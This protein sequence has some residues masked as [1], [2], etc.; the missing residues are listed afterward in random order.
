[1]SEPTS[2]F[3]RRDAVANKAPSLFSGSP[4][5]TGP[6][7]RALALLA[8]VLVIGLILV[9]VFG[10]Y[11]RRE[12]VAGFIAPTSGLVRVVPPRM[13]VVTRVEVIDD[14][15]VLAG[16]ALLAI[17]SLRATA[18]GGD[19]DAAHVVALEQ[20]RLNLAARIAREAELAEARTQDTARRIGELQ[21][22]VKKIQ[23]QR[24]LAEERSELL[25]REL[26]RLESLKA[27]A[28]ISASLLDERR[29][30]V[31]TAQQ[32]D[33]ALAREQ[34]RLQSG[35][36]ALEAELGLKPLELSARQDELAARILEID[37]R[38]AEAEVQ[39]E[40][41][42]RAPVS[43]RVTS[44]LAFPGQ[45]VTPNQAMLAI[46]PD[47]ARM[48]A[49]LLVPS[50]AAGFIRNGQEVRL[51]YDAFPHQRFGVHRA[52]VNSVSRTMLKPGDQV[53]PLSLQSPA[54]RV[55][56]TL[57]ADSVMAYGE[58]IPLQPDLTLQAD[59]VRE[60][61]RIIEWIFD[62]VRAAVSAL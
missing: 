52:V 36:A 20:E 5:Q 11:E 57:D 56:A 7:V 34:E 51:R 6:A 1:M 31:L 3:F 9:L 45:S 49:V 28:H 48:Q 16:Q 12:R 33:T 26:V 53:G 40:T 42:V 60:R 22:Q 46:L 15:Q 27:N 54:Y 17:S 44:L 62:P 30:E 41:L 10:T 35:I 55:I 8:L 14:E 13:G 24:V 18:D 37:R 39:R 23:E 50:Q 25:R 2:Q 38:L 58:A 47:D 43:G 32:N 19:A 61:L 29:R 4:I 59:I 21:R